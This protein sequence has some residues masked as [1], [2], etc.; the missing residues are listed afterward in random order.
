MCS[1]D[2]YVMT[3]FYVKN[4]S[5][6]II[7]FDASVW[8]SSEILGPHEVSESFTVYPSDSVL[9][10]RV[11]WM[12][13]NKKWFTDFTIY[14]IEGVQMNDPN[15]PENWIKHHKNGLPIYVFTLNNN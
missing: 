11:K 5:D 4:T 9:A 3:E 15:L 14:P 1:D 6:K 7:R 2:E 8:K 12:K 10:R 13:E